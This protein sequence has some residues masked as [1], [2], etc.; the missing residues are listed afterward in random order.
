MGMPAR[1]LARIAYCMLHGGQWKNRQIIPE[2]FVNESAAPTHDVKTPELRWKL[3]PQIF[4]HG[5][6]LPARLTGEGGR[7]G[8]GIP[9]DARA[10]P[11]SAGST[12]PSSE[13]GSGHYAPDR[14]QWR[15]AIR[16]VSAPS[17][18][19]GEVK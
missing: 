7:S 15:V 8:S 17:V 11:G 18:R 16:G 14:Q 1:D 4:S 13:P 5:W 6:E 3:N 10:K 12:S 9:A 19:G 2:W